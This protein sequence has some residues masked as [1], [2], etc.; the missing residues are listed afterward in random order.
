MIL[1]DQFAPVKPRSEHYFLKHPNANIMLPA[2]PISPSENFCTSEPFF[3]AYERLL[4]SDH[5]VLG[6]RLDSELATDE[7]GGRLAELEQAEAWSIAC[8]VGLDRGDPGGF[9]V[10]RNAAVPSA[11]AKGHRRGIAVP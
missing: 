5:D 9:R 8:L 2:D 4:G 7:P 3:S 6:R 10:W 1:K 11:S